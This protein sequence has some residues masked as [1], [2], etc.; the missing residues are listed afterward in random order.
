M[1][2]QDNEAI[3]DAAPF[4]AMRR[5]WQPVLRSVDLPVGAVRSV[6]LLDRPLALWRGGSGAVGAVDD[7]CPHRGARFGIGRVHGDELACPYHGWRFA[8]T[9]VC[10]VIPSQPGRIPAGAAVGAYPVRERYGL[11]WVLLAPPAIAPLPDI[12]AFEDPAWTYLVAEPMDFATGFRRE[13]ENYLDMSHFAFAHASSLGA[14]ADPCIP[15]YDIHEHDDGF[16]MEA[17]FPALAGG[18]A[19]LSRLQRAHHRTQRCHL[20]NFTTIR[21]QWPEGHARVLVHVPSPQ[22]A[23]SCR[24]FWALAISPDFDGPSPAEQLRFAVD[25]LDEDRRMCENQEPAEVPLSGGD[26]LLV[27]A[28]RLAVTY[29]RALRAFCR[30]HAACS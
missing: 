8:C 6:R 9:G 26:G 12:P 13:I 17:P 2:Q 24:V 15:R 25:V 23:T 20:P 5:T 18:D 10:T 19:A 4:R 29:R 21:Q 16:R 3:D 22:T 7:R 11:V 30:R 1:D 28:D 14:A 27:A